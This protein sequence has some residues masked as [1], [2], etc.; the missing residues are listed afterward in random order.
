MALKGIIAT[1]YFRTGS[2]FFFSCLRQVQRF[3]CF[4]EPYHPELLEFINSL[5][6]DDSG[7]DR[8]ALGHSLGDDYFSEFE[9]LD[10]IALNDTYG[11]ERRI[12]NQ[13]VLHARSVH[14]DLF[15]Y[16]LFLENFA[17]QH[18]QINVLQANRLNFAMPWLKSNFPDYLL[19]LI[20]RN[21]QAVFS[22]LQSLGSKDGINID[23]ED[24]QCSYWN[25]SEAFENIVKH[26]GFYRNNLPSF[27]YYQKLYFVLKFSERVM[28]QSADIIMSYEQFLVNPEPVF[29]LIG[30][31]MQ[32]D[33]QLSVS[34]AKA[35]V[36]FNKENIKNYYLSELE[37]APLAFLNE[38]TKHTHS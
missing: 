8:E 19:I 20:T 22:S 6:D 2:T 32:V 35:N 34:Y 16:I 12:T 23:A 24:S 33:T 29:T 38:V 18:E 13:P 9:G 1:G 30:N 4:Y 25:V 27:G 31:A 36:K 21:P 11:L 7:P 26:Y 37:I 28:A 3:R 14:D 17:N 5:G 15:N 10:K